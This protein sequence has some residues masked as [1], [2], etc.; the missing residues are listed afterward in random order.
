MQELRL[1]V[2]G[3]KVALQS[4]DDEGRWTHLYIKRCETI[5]PGVY[6]L[7][8]AKDPLPGSVHTGAVLARHDA[9][10][11]QE[12]GKAIVRHAASIFSDISVATGDVVTLDYSGTKPA[13]SPVRGVQVGKRKATH[14]L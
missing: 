6:Q 7:L 14:K 13:I 1:I 2:M 5:Q 11:Y 3:G 8:K 10:V 4:M 9:F 12:S